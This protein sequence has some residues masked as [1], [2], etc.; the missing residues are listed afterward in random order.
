MFN[1]ISITLQHLK[2]ND[3]SN[4]LE[5]ELYF[6]T[7]SASCKTPNIFLSRPT[8][9]RKELCTSMKVN[10]GGRLEG[11]IWCHKVRMFPQ[12]SDLPWITRDVNKFPF[13]DSF[14]F[15]SSITDHLL[16]R[17]LQRSGYA[18]SLVPLPSRHCISAYQIQPEP[19]ALGLKKKEGRV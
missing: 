13:L 3:M 9:I 17:L 10:G 7:T 12:S 15:I 2:I 18:L 14:C 16:A 6:F 8:D 4:W 5:D 11:F 1:G 19:E